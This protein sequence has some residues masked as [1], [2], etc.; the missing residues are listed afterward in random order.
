MARLNI[1]CGRTPTPGWRNFDNS[2]SLRLARLGGLPDLLGRLRLLGNAQRE[3]IAFARDHAIEYGDATRGLPLPAGSCDAI[4]SSHMLEHLDREGAD[5]FLR[6]ALRLL[7]PGGVLRLAVP[8]LRKPIEEYMERGDVDHFLA[9]AYVCV[10]RPRTVTDRLKMAL[11]GPRHHQWMYDGPSLVA[12]LTRHGFAD[13]AVTPAGETRIPDPGA[14]DL[15][16]REDESVY[17]EATRP[18]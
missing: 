4:Y 12:L 17:V 14:L 2:P 9:Q 7:R 10:P 11:V 1:G 18:A 8:D 13:P 6:E 15:A 3:F 5:A 16:E